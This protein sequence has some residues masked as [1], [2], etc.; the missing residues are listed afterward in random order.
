M[1]YL[2]KHGN[3]STSFR[4]VTQSANTP[5]SDVNSKRGRGWGQ[6]YSVLDELGAVGKLVLLAFQL[7]Q[8]R[9]KRINVD[10]IR[11]RFLNRH[12]IEIIA[13]WVYGTVGYT[14][15]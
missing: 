13:R 14:S 10:H 8:A 6:Y 11:G 9:Q 5:A 4:C 2:T 1:G 12:R 7:R 15:E 3:E